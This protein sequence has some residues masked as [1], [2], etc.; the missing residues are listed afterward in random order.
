MFERE[1]KFIYDFSLN[2]VNKLGPYFTFEQLSAVELHPAVL[3]YISAEID[4]IIFEDRQKLLKDSIFDYSGEKIS[5]YFSLI[6]EEIK[7][8]KRLSF[9][10]VSKLILHSTSFTI[11]YLVRPKWTLKKFIFDED[12]HRTTTEIKQIL[13]YV[14]YYNYLK[15]ILISYINSK[16]ILSMNLQE[17][18]E[19]L[20]KIDNI[21]LETNFTKILN[22]A[23]TSMADFFNIG[24]IQKSKIPLQAIELFL[25][26]KN[27]KE[28]LKKLQIA[29]GNDKTIKCNIK[30]LQKELTSVMLEEK[31]TFEEKIELTSSQEEQVLAS[32]EEK[33]IV[34]EISIKEP[35]ES[36][37]DENEI[38]NRNV[39]LEKSQEYVL[40]ETEQEY[41]QN[42]S[43]GEAPEETKTIDD[44]SITYKPQKY[45]IRVDKNNEIEPLNE[46]EAGDYDKKES[47]EEI[48][49]STNFFEKEDLV[50]EDETK[51]NTKDAQQDYK[52]S[53]EIEHEND[54]SENEAIEKLNTEE[55]Y[56]KLENIDILKEENI[57]EDKNSYVSIDEYNEVSQNQKREFKSININEMMEDKEVTRIIE[58]IFDYD[59]EDF[60]NVLEMLSDCNTQEEA[61]LFVDKVLSNRNFDLKSK[62][63]ELFK[64]VIS[65]YFKSEQ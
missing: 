31:L 40:D 12:E 18:S 48:T 57:L 25:E 63:A 43:S 46:T 54:I 52:E 28:H 37:Y 35:D 20:D 36:I 21:G 14:Y 29:F 4:Y 58:V 11:N 19:L 15:K 53:L 64:S 13:N 42:D 38:D 59:I 33:E 10:Y 6:N 22:S 55:E 17:F 39:E 47:Q 24:E 2:K 26:E 62:E 50:S 60:S 16:K 41:Q 23:L 9:E 32:G 5:Y 27:L 8:T 3:N 45:R 7:K 61:F 30:D 51:F 34:D 49:I 65:K 1:I 56:K 44:V